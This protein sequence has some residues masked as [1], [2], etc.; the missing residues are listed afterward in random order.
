MLDYLL[1]LNPDATRNHD[2]CGM[3]PIALVVNRAPFPEQVEM[4]KHLVHADPRSCR[5]IVQNSTSRNL[6]HIFASAA[7][8]Y[9]ERNGL[10]VLFEALLEL[11]PRGCLL[12]GDIDHALPL[13]LLCNL[14]TKTPVGIMS[15]MIH[16]SPEAVGY[17]EN[18][19]RL[20]LQCALQYSSADVIKVLFDATYTED[21]VDLFE[22]LS[23]KA[24]QGCRNPDIIANMVQTH[25]AKFPDSVRVSQSMAT[26]EL[27]LHCACYRGAHVEVVKLLYKK[28]PDAITHFSRSGRLP[29]HLAIEH[30]DDAILSTS[31]L[32]NYA[33]VIRFLVRSCPRTANMKKSFS[34]GDWPGIGQRMTQTPIALSRY[35]SLPVF[36]QRLL[37]CACPEAD[38]KQWRNL[39]YR[40][41]REVMLLAFAAISRQIGPGSMVW[42]L[43]RLMHVDRS[44]SL[45]KHVVSFI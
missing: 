23:S 29:L 28:Y 38:R 45:L 25:T 4:V 10:E 14:G 44:M 43:R 13:H 5:A 7:S 3:M 42:Q 6:L 1:V 8:R 17:R 32:S 11:V 22:I 36:V 41:R 27:A 34:D 30:Y 35:R 2:G 33:D 37:L 40:A 31:L 16:A 9:G 20:P 26:G 21:N 15:M 19:K 12:A 24:L 18:M 39:N